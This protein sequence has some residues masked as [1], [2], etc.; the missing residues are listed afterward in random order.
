MRYSSLGDSGLIVSV[1]GL[2][3]NNFGSRVDLA[4]IRAVVD[5]GIT[6]F[7]TADSYGDGGLPGRAAQPRA[8]AVR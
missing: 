3:C 2:G 8:T 5:A 4:G 7:D 6:L 1:A